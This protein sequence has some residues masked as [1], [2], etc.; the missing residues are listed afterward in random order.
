METI[1]TFVL[2]GIVAFAVIMY[3]FLDGF[4][5]GIGI[6][7]PWVKSEES[8]NILVASI[9]PVWDG[10]ETW[11]VL[12]GAALYG[13]FPIV[14][15]FV[16]PALYMPIMMMLGGLILR[17]VSF[18]FMHNSHHSR[19]IWVFCFAFGSTLAA[20]CQGIVLGTFVQGFEFE[21]GQMVVKTYQWLTPFSMMC[22][23]AVIFGYALLGTTWSVLRTTG[24]LQDDMRHRAKVL[25]LMVGMFMVVLS[26][27]T[28]FVDP[29]AT[30]YW[31]SMP[32]ML[33]LGLLPL[34]T[35]FT[36]IA[37][38]RALTHGC[39]KRPFYMSFLLFLFPY[40][41]FALTVWPYIIPR[42]VTLW[43]AAAP[44]KAQL[45]ILVGLIILIP[46]L[47]GYTAYSYYVFKGKV[48]AKDIH[49]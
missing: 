46:I 29:D 38:W 20:F 26:L 25:L 47:L 10:N 23:I 5:L 2:A 36:F 32:N 35:L 49:Y 37:I 7:F 13:A 12:G 1:V 21:G 39:D 6:L 33:Y 18:E 48:T 24:K 14:Y 41:G 22:G 11:L 27:W 31:F 19:F 4:D 34:A 43:E 3:V 42:H 17:G 30:K 44:L 15:S 8:R 45:F 40:L 16:L 28:P 9:L